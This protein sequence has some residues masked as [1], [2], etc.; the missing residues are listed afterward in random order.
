MR[1]ERS[2]IPRLPSH[3][4]SVA[5]RERLLQEMAARYPGC[6]TWAPDEALLA[7]L[8]VQTFEAEGADQ[9][10]WVIRRCGLPVPPKIRH[11]RYRLIK[12]LLRDW[13]NPTVRERILTKTMHVPVKALRRQFETLT[14]EKALGL[15]RQSGAPHL[16]TPLRVVGLHKEA[17]AVF[18]MLDEEGLGLYRCDVLM[19]QIIAHRL[20]READP[21]ATPL[22][23]RR[24]LTQRLRRRTHKLQALRRSLYQLGQERKGLVR[25]AWEAER[26]TGRVL[27]QLTAQQAELEARLAGAIMAHAERLTT[28]QAQQ[29]AALQVA[30][31]R[32]EERRAEYAEALAER[33]RWASPH[34]LVGQ[35]ILVVGDLNHEAGYRAVIEEMG[36]R[37][38]IVDGLD[39]L[40]R[41]REVAP[42]A[43]VAILIS[44]AAKH[45]AEATLAATLSPACI[46]LY[47]P[48]AGQ[49]SLAR[50]IR[51]ALLPR[52]IAR[53]VAAT[54]QGGEHD[55]R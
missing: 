5:F 36:G 28:A 1:R 18:A 51:T 13:S 27:D 45:A 30:R 55:E 33:R 11:D 49:A 39:R 42:E 53:T 48:R 34:P 17:D 12:C 6:T 46:F 25:L 20:W 16:I 23:D 47:C 19:A 29:A 40:G 43:D 32:L 8:V 10:A 3:G 50:T 37:A 15:M 24:V 54:Q 44:A 22:R 2:F 7:S 4:P 31:E 9:V 52:Q 21:A 41:I 35:S 14:P 38:I 26:A